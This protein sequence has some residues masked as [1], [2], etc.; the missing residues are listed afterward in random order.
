MRVDTLII[1]YLVAGLLSGLVVLFVAFPYRR[2]PVPKAKRITEAVV[3]VAE[4]VDP[5]EAPPLGVLTTPEKSRR[6]SRR[7]ERFEQRVRRG[8]RVLSHTGPR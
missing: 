5:G 7:F 4:R 8:L 2:R 6:M 1:A 3:S